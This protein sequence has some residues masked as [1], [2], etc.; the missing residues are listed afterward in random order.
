MPYEIS[1]EDGMFVVRKKGGGKAFGKHRTKAEAEAQLRAL[2]AGEKRAAARKSADGDDEPAEVLIYAG[3][4]VKAAGESGEIAG[5]AVRWGSP[6][7][8][9][10]TPTKDY[11]T[12]ETHFGR[13]AAGPID[14]LY[15]HG[16]PSVKG[17]PNALAEVEIGRATVARDDEGLWLAGSLDLSIPGVAELW[18]Q[19]KADDDAFGLSSGAVSHRVRRVPQPNGSHWLKRWDLVEVSIT[20]EPGEPRT[21]AVALKSLLEDSDAE[22]F[23]D[24]CLKAAS[25]LTASTA[26]FAKIGPSKRQAIVELRDALDAA[27]KAAAPPEHLAELAGLAREAES[28]RALLG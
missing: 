4:A 21:A 13:Y 22:S 26:R 17:R 20:P 12:P 2:D 18:G 6:E 27:I 25:D 9:D 24:S 15:H 7:L 8:P 16:L 19:L 10:R 11:F 1:H 23:V 14:L 5:Y 3:G 28:L